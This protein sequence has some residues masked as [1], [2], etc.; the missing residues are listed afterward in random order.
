EGPTDD[1]AVNELRRRQQ[2][3]LL[4][5]LL[6]SQGTPMI[7]A[8]DEFGRT[9]KGNNNAYCQ[10]NEISWLDWK[11]TNDQAA[12]QD[13]A[14]RVLR[15]RRAHPGLHRSKFF[16]GQAIHDGA[17][18][19]LAWFRHDGKPMSPDDWS[20]PSTQSLTMFLAGRGI[21]DVD[22]QGRPLLDDNLLLIVNASHLDLVFAMP[23]VAQVKDDWQLLVDTADDRAEESVPPGGKTSLKGRSIKLFISPSHVIR[24]GGALHTLGAT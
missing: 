19:D 11:W 24:S 9:Q 10:D 8:G 22:D 3:N 20:N 14:R 7:L 16:Q 23:Q 2:R 17:Q 6:L 12:L 1:P 4:A 21:N 13:F 5:T 15:V 18:Q